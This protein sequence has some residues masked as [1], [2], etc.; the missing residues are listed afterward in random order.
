MRILVAHLVSSAR[1]GG[2]SR[3]MGRVHDL[4][5]A[6]G[7][8][9][10]YLT[11]DHVGEAVQSR[12]GRFAFQMLVRRAAIDAERSGRP[13]DIV[14]VHEPHAAAI[15][16]FRRGLE[17]TAVVAMTHGLEQRGWDIARYHIHSRPALKTRL[18]YPISTLWLAR[19]ALGRAD[20]VICLN[21]VDRQFLHERFH[22]D[23]SNITPVTPGADVVFGEAAAARNY[24]RGHRLLFAGTWIP[25]K[26]VKELS[27]AFSRLVE[28]GVDVRLDIIGGGVPE[29]EIRA[30]FSGSA[31]GRVHALAGGGD[32]EIAA[33]MAE[34]DV[35]VLPS[36]F[37]GTPL[38]L[39]EA[40]W[41][42]LPIVTTATAGMRDVV[43]HERTGLLV[44]P[45]ESAALELALER[46]IC[47][48]GLRRLLGTAA[49]TIASS[50][51]TWNNA[52]AA[53]EAA[54]Q[55]GR[56]RHG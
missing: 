53:F 17:H 25:R 43:A 44:P 56:R 42:G 4:L 13:F 34:A 26:G 50:R 18:T 41:S 37:E 14:N 15:A 7:H 24:V 9:I 48:S 47:D 36:V 45:G 10:H 6:A 8:E 3:L 31:A 20:H 46:V 19:L 30:N 33:A 11:A 12:W 54:Y 16:L 49:H 55:A 38:T 32:P 52:A 51:Y 1:T 2:M 29:S 23:E 27:E 28:R 5:E 40:M 35:F 21:T 39:V 22:I